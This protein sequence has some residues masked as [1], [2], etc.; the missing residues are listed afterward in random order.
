MF[1]YI[2]IASKLTTRLG[3]VHFERTVNIRMYNRNKNNTIRN[4]TYTVL[5]PAYVRAIQR[6]SQSN[7]LRYT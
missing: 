4:V 2:F 3:T 5:L 1:Y 6:N 7:S